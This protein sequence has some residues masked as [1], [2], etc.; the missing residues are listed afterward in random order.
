M[1][2]RATL[3]AAF[4]FVL[5]SVAIVAT[6]HRQE[7]APSVAPSSPDE[8]PVD[9]DSRDG[10]QNP[11]VVVEPPTHDAAPTLRADY[12]KTGIEAF[13]E[14]REVP[15]V[16]L[17]DDLD[18]LAAETRD[19]DWSTQMEVR[20]QSEIARAGL[21]LT[22]S[23]VECRTSICAVAL[24]R[25]TGVFDQR[26]QVGLPN[27]TITREM[28][29]AARTLGL[30]GSRRASQILARNG[31]LVHWQRFFRRCASDGVCLQ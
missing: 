18:E 9:S 23:Y 10:P 28:A 30:L 16:V 24:V 3:W 25:P 15:I 31:A 2:L 19:P 17:R 6:R 7:A 29:D 21:T 4:V 26:E 11:I 14:F 5:A 1:P 20:L 13:L 8:T 27:G 22:G 12:A